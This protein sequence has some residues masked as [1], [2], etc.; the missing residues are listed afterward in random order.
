M[1]GS[2]APAGA[3]R[4]AAIDWMRGLVMVL[5]TL[6]HAS[7]AFNGE[8]IAVDS[9]Y[10]LD[11][12][13]GQPQHAPGSVLPALQFGVRWVTH[14]CA[15][16]FLFLSGTSLALSL[17]RRRGAGASERELD[18]HLLV[19]GAVILGC[20]AF[21]SLLAWQGVL[22]LQV[23]YAIGLSLWLMIPLRRLDPRLLVTLALGWIVAGEWVT[24]TLFP[25]GTTGVPLAGRLLL[26]PGYTAPVMVLY[27]VLGW[28][29]ML[30]LGWGFGAWLGARPAGA[31]G[32]SAARAS[33][34]A[35]A[36][37]LLVFALVRSVD[38][39]GNLG[40]HRDDGSL[41]QW[42]HVS[43]Y[44]PALSFT[45]L[46]LGLMGL[47]LG[48]AFALESRLARPPSRWNPLRVWGE[49][50]L[51]YYM[52]HFIGL[53]AAALALTGGI[54]AH[55][56]GATALATLVALLGLYPVCLAW[57]SYKRAHPGG[58]AQYF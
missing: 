13:T 14:L 20:E 4:L 40:L 26:V 32:A 52:L 34:A 46:E 7:M 57:R 56:L 6:D 47:L 11:P 5:M 33:G 18:R 37:A 10:M 45:A 36:A 30:A 39:Y 25:I 2:A 54:G 55:G 19:R 53:P 42:L 8:R 43:K 24:T 48:A 50:A 12:R 16:T 3:G 51:L 28:L 22:I 21:I 23:L 9:A 1:T 27:P 35:G 29:A 15:P 44:P 49:T 17:G 41:V 31:R 38:A 58:W